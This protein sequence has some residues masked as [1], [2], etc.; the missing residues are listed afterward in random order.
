MSRSYDVV[1]VGIGAMGSAVVYQLAIDLQ[2]FG[3]D[4]HL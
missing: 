3:L 2:P 1:V 4:R